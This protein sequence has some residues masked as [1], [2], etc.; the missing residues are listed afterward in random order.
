MWTDAHCHLA[1]PR[2][3]DDARAVVAR[4]RAAGVDAWVQGGVSP[5][6]WDRQRR[7]RDWVGAGFFP[8]FGLH[9]WWVAEKTDAEV[10]SALE[11]LAALMAE[12]P[13]LGETGLDSGARAG[14]AV[15]LERQR[16]SF[17]RHVELAREH[18]KPLVLHVVREHAEAARILAAHG[19][20]P[21]GGIVHAFSG[22]ENAARAYVGLGLH[23][24]VNAGV[25]RESFR[26]LR[27]AL[28]TLPRDRL[29]VETDAPDGALAG[30]V[31]EPA[32]LP[33]VATALGRVLG[34]APAEALLAASTQAIRKLI[35]RGT[36]P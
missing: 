2:L 26:K 23:I 27:R 19:P 3:Y 11:Q 16:R 35:I 22:D 28:P 32:T 13:F 18:E 25:A 4:S 31:A 5:E 34:D 17:V 10:D 8:A 29:L 6:D 20:L 36:S 24:S 15:Y 14:G 21:A 33:A 9:P 30:H 1:D 12:T 7:L